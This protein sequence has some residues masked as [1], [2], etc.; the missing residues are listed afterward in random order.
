MSHRVLDAAFDR[1]A[2]AAAEIG[3]PAW[4]VDAVKR[5]CRAPGEDAPRSLV[6]HAEIM[7]AIARETSA[8]EHEHQ[9]FFILDW[10]TGVNLVCIREIERR[11]KHGW[12]VT[13][14]PSVGCGESMA[15]IAADPSFESENFERWIS[16]AFVSGDAQAKHT[17]TLL[18]RIHA[19]AVDASADELA[20]G[21]FT[22]QLTLAYESAVMMSSVA[23]SMS[24]IDDPVAFLEEAVDELFATLP[25]AWAAFVRSDDEDLVRIVAQE[26]IVRFESS[27]FDESTIVGAARQFQ[28]A[29]NDATVLQIE[30]C[31]VGLDPD[32]GPEIIVLPLL[33]DGSCRA[34]LLLGA[35]EGDEWA[36]SS[37]DTLPVRAIGASITAFLEII[38]AYQRQQ[39]SFV[40]TLGGLSKALD[41][42]DTYT[43]GHSDRVA[44]L[45]AELARA[46]GLDEDQVRLVHIAGIVHD[47]G[48]IG[49]PEAVLQ[50]DQKLT[51]EE[52]AQIRSHPTIGYEILKN[53]PML[54]EALP[55]VLHHHEKWD[56]S[57]YPHKITGEQTPMIARILALVD[58]FDAMS[59]NRSYQ[60]GQKREE[61]LDEIRR[62]RGTHFDPELVDRF[63]ELDF[64]VYD[65]MI[66]SGV[67]I[68]SRMN[69]KERRSRDRAA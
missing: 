63:L 47:I 2:E 54:K 9:D 28:D 34:M 12:V 29:F 19:Q 11:Q 5:E 17:A 14:L 30:P 38:L 45:G 55:G 7:N 22:T 33:I 26:S 36:V 57:G 50:G 65:Q 15:E 43:R 35:R 13:M 53:I 16:P 49:V 39:D 4:R 67:P 41:A 58:A 10:R 20:I 40:G 46:S 31:P 62:C 24:R 69:G 51:D 59:S 56:G 68:R 60:T 64:S 61:V 25:F 48:K 21:D 52:F 23:E 3:L 8:L 37:Y 32:L 44:Y 66:E 18:R 27:R 1:F 42:K 6:C